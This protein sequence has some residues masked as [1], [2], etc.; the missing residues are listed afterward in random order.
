MSYV[1][2]T[3]VDQIKR[4]INEIT[5][6]YSNIDCDIHVWTDEEYEMGAQRETLLYTL[7]QMTGEWL[8]DGEFYQTNMKGK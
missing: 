4:R 2:Y 3:Q 1:F 8:C 5:E 6:Y 7:H